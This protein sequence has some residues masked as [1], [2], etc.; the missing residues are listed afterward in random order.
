MCDCVFVCA[1]SPPCA[2]DTAVI[3]RPLMLTTVHTSRTLTHTLC[4]VR[5]TIHTS[6]TAA[7]SRTV[8]CLTYDQ[9]PQVCSPT[10]TALLPPLL[11]VPLLVHTDRSWSMV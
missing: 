8:I 3:A 9:Q 10:L 1:P 7:V 2:P 4:T 6:F 5:T 11:I